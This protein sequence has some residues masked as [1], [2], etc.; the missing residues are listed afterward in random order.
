[1]LAAI[2]RR[3]AYD[4]ALYKGSTKLHHLRL[5]RSAHEWMFR[6]SLGFTSFLSICAI[7]DQNPDEI[8]E[9]TLLLTKKDV[10]KYDMVDVHDRVYR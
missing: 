4:I 1:M 3:A 2:V 10:R 5:W 9:K 7:L 6:P 8:R